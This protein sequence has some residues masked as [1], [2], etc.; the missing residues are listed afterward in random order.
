MKGTKFLFA[1]AVGVVILVAALLISALLYFEPF[2]Y[3]ADDTPEGV[4]HN[5]LLALQRKDYERARSYLLT[6]LPGYPADVEQFAADVDRLATDASRPPY[7]IN[8]YKVEVSLVVEPTQVFDDLATVL[9][10][11]TELQRRAPFDNEQSSYTFYVNLQMV[12]G[13]W[14]ISWAE[15]YWSDCWSYRDYPGCR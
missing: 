11:R 7:D 9:V 4:V 3:R 5:Y 2:Q 8:W 6:T 13:A 12:D 10:R 1:I 14:K 15:R